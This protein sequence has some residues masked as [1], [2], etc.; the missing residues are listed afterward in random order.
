MLGSLVGYSPAGLTHQLLNRSAEV[1]AI[2]VWPEAAVLIA[3]LR[4]VGRGKVTRF[5][6][7]GVTAAVISYVALASGM[8]VGA[9]AGVGVA[10]ALAVPEVAHLASYASTTAPA[11][12]VLLARTWQRRE[13]NDAS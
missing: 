12:Q 13:S 6:L 2:W 3:M 5:A 7:T 8:F 11:L 1:Q 10:L 4:R 9:L